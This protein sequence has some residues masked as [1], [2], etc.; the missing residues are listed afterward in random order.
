MATVGEQLTAPESGWKRYDDKESN[1]SYVGSGW[2]S[3]P[4]GNSWQGTDQCTNVVGDM[5]KFNFT[6]SRIRYISWMFNNRTNAVAITIDGVPYTFSQYGT[7][8]QEPQ[9]LVFEKTGLSGTEHY[10][11]VMSQSSGYFDL[12]AIDLDETGELKPY[13]RGKVLLRITM[14]DSSEREYQVSAEEGDEFVK[15][16]NRT[17]DTGNSHYMFHKVVGEQKSKEYVFFEKIISFEVV[18]IK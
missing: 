9:K 5:I 10:V 16:S 15:W 11:T 4:G 18:E 8:T 3:N 14:N 13:S 7:Q 2:F 12:D 17:V 1:I 6:G